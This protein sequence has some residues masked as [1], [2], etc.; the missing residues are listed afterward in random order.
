MAITLYDAT[1]PNFL[2]VVGSL[3]GVLQRALRVPR[4]V[5]HL[6]AQREHVGDEPRL[7]ELGRI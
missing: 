2:Q 6:Q 5:L 7:D 4:D 1:V 3:R